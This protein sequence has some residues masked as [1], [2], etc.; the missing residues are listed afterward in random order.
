MKSDSGATDESKEN[1]HSK[2]LFKTMEESPDIL[3]KDRIKR[4]KLLID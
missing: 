2:F 3:I 1:D 4:S